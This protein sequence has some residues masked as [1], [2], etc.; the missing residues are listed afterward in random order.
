M[1][2]EDLLEE[3]ED[4]EKYRLF[5]KYYN[6]DELLTKYFPNCTNRN[7][8]YLKSLHDHIDYN[9][10]ENISFSRWSNLNFQNKIFDL[11]GEFKLEIL[12]NRYEYNDDYDINKEMHWHKNFA[13]S[14]LFVGYHSSLFAQDEIQV[15]EH[16]ILA[17]LLCAIDDESE[18]NC[19]PLTIENRLP[20]P[21]IIQNA[22]RKIDIDTVNYPIYGNAFA[23][24]YEETIKQATNILNPPT[25]T[26][27]LCIQAPPCGFG[28]YSLDTIKHI[29]STAYSGYK[30]IKFETSE[31]IGKTG[32]CVLHT[33]NWGCGAYGGNHYIMAILQILAAKCAQLDKVVYHAYNQKLREFVEQSLNTIE[34]IINQESDINWIN[35]DSCLLRIYNCKFQW[36]SSDGN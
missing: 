10:E 31:K 4:I 9:R 14:H 1:N 3:K 8:I 28:R 15:A 33:G 26:N 6:V 18:E 2:S 12:A 13:D 16:P 35:I 21:I 20:R 30:A 7:K 34:N 36:N 23:R 5:R 19:K 22:V 24:A 27:L 29:F 32:V 25:K 11:N 17:N